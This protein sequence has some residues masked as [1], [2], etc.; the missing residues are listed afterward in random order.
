MSFWP[1][2]SLYIP[3]SSSAAGDGTLGQRPLPF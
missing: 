3:Y 2:I 1:L